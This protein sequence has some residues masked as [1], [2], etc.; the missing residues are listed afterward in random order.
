ML[1]TSMPSLLV[2]VSWRANICAFK[3]LNISHLARLR[4]EIRNSEGELVDRECEAQV[5][6]NYTLIKL[7]SYLRNC[8]NGCF[9]Q[10]IIH[11]YTCF[12]LILAI[13]RYAKSD[14]ANT[15]SSFFPNVPESTKYTSI[16]MSWS[17]HSPIHSW[18]SLR[19]H[20]Q[21][22]EHCLKKVQAEKKRRRHH[23]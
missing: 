7:I 22:P 23:K 6:Y 15:N 14:M 19:N 3:L 21:L 11:H 13:F 17:F 10:I 5:L 8:H 16:A 1:S 4:V 9:F 2:Q 20:L 12:F 18:Q